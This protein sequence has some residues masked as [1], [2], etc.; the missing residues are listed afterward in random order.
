MIKNP[1]LMRHTWFTPKVQAARS[2]SWKTKTAFTPIRTA[3]STTRMKTEP[4]QT[5]TTQPTR[6]LKSTDNLDGYKTFPPRSQ[7]LDAADFIC[8]DNINFRARSSG[9]NEGI[10]LCYMNLTEYA[11]GDP[12]KT[13]LYFR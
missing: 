11:E 4:S 12:G 3:L 10:A 7:R 5:S 1:F 9:A 13:F 6:S 2:A 8:F